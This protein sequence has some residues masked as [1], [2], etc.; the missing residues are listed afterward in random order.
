LNERL[1]L[2]Y[3]LLKKHGVKSTADLVEIQKQFE[4]KLQ[5]VM[6]IDEAY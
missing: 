3:R 4:Q 5:A 1:S 2:G 6:N